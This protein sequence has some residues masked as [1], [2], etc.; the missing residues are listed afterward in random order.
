M[1]GLAAVSPC[2]RPGGGAGSAGTR[3]EQHSCQLTKNSAPGA[4]ATGSFQPSSPARQR[5]SAAPKKSMR[6]ESWGSRNAASCLRRRKVTITVRIG[7]RFRHPVT[8]ETESGPQARRD[9]HAARGKSAGTKAG[10]FDIRCSVSN[11]FSLWSWPDQTLQGAK[12]AAPEASRS[13]TEQ[14]PSK[15]QPTTALSDRRSVA[16]RRPP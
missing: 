4:S 10:T 2:S 3:E 7:D 9:G 11:S 14:R 16:A 5:S 12:R 1:Q 6:F 15:T 13:S 8:M